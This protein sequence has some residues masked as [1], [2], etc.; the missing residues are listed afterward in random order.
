MGRAST[1]DNDKDI[2][3]FEAIAVG[4]SVARAADL[5]GYSLSSVNRW[6]RENLPFRSRFLSAVNEKEDRLMQEVN[7]RGRD[8]WLEPVYYKGQVC[9]QVRKYSDALLKYAHEAAERSAKEITEDLARFNED[10]N[11]VD[12]RTPAV[13]LILNGMKFKQA[14]GD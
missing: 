6:K 3:F 8:G 7:R 5:A 12:A 10:E 13:Q 11:E 2:A 14:D 4:H 9:G 1:R